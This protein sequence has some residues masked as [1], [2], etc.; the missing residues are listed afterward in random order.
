[1]AASAWRTYNS[2]KKYLQ[3]ADIDLNAGTLRLGLYKA[4]S[5]C[6][7]YTLT[8]FSQ[9]TGACSAGL[10]TQIKTPPSITVSTGSSAKAIQLSAGALIFSASAASA[11]SV[12]NAVMFI[13]GGKLI[14][15]CALSTAGFSVTAGNTL[16]ITMN[17]NGVWELSGGTA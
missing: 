2:A 14:C 12:Q 7:T 4:N 16:T 13:S 8:T 5:N 11:F 10:I 15:W 9:L 3:T 1:M 6:S 17:T